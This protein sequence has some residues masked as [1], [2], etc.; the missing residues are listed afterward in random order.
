M[1]VA[2]FVRRLFYESSRIV[3]DRLGRLIF[4]S[5]E[6]G[7]YREAALPCA[8]E[9]PRCGLPTVT[10]RREAQP[11]HDETVASRQLDSEL[12]GGGALRRRVRKHERPCSRVRRG[13][14][15]S[16][17]TSPLER[18]GNLHGSESSVPATFGFGAGAAWLM[19]LRLG[20]LSRPR[21]RRHSVGTRL[22]DGLALLRLGDRRR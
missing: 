22:L 3:V 4:E 13:L 6:L 14:G 20:V 19:G 2:P 9:L 15:R 12:A 11:S 5:L 1:S 8:L 18:A 10:D 21:R 16:K 17:A 7:M